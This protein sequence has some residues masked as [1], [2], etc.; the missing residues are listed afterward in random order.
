MWARHDGWWEEGDD[1]FTSMGG[2]SD[3][4]RRPGSSGAQA[5]STTTD[6]TTIN[7]CVVTIEG[8]GKIYT[9]SYSLRRDGTKRSMNPHYLRA[10][11]AYF[12]AITGGERAG[13]INPYTGLGYRQQRD[14]VYDILEEDRVV[15]AGFSTNPPEWNNQHYGRGISKK[16]ITVNEMMESEYEFFVFKEVTDAY[17]FT[18]PN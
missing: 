8:C 3:S 6:T 4:S 2:N 5:V 14:I 12:C 13:P 15:Y 17:D 7:V 1:I 18:N 10:R 11:S 9:P 16:V